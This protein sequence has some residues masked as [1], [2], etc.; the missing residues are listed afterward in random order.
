MS[1]IKHNFMG[2]KMNKDLDERLIPNGEYRDAM[3]IQVSTS[4]GS[5]VGTVQNILGNEL[6]CSS[7]ITPAG[8]VTVGSIADEKNDALYWLVAG[9]SFD[10]IS[11]VDLFQNNLQFASET[12]GGN[13]YYAKDMI[14]RRTTDGCEPVLVD[15][16]GGIFPNYDAAS[17]TYWANT[18]DNSIVLSNPDFLDHIHPGMSVFGIN[19]IDGS[20]TPQTRMVTNVGNLYSI[21]TPYTLGVD[22]LVSATVN[23]NTPLPVVRFVGVI[24]PNSQGV[25]SIALDVIFIEN[26]SSITGGI[27][28][29][30]TL[31]T[32]VQFSFPNNYFMQNA[33]VT[34]ILGGGLF[35]IDTNLGA[36]ETNFNPNPPDTTSLVGNNGIAYYPYEFGTMGAMGQITV[37][38]TSF[39]LT[40]QVIFPENSQWLNEISDLFFDENYVLR[41]VL[42]QLQ[43][44]AS[45][46]WPNGG[47]IDTSA[48]SLIA[49]YINGNGDL[50]YSNDY[51]IVDCNSGI[52]FANA[53][54][55][56]PPRDLFLSVL[57]GAF[58][59]EVVT[60]DGPLHLL[61]T[62]GSGFDYLVFTKERVLNF[63]P[64]KQ[65]TGI[66]II[67]DML[68]WVDGREDMTG[69]SKVVGTEPKKINIKRS[70]AGTDVSGD[71][72]TRLIN[73][74]ISTTGP[75]LKEEHI[76]VIRQSPKSALDFDFITDRE[77]DK[78][79]SGIMNIC[80]SSGANTSSFIDSSQDRRDFNNIKEGDH[81]KIKIE[82]DLDNS[83]SF[84][85][86]WKEGTV[87][88]LQ[89]FDEDDVAPPVPFTG[90]EYRIKGVIAKWK[91]NTGSLNKMTSTAGDPAQVSILVTSVSGFPPQTDTTLDYVVDTYFDTEKLFEFKFPRFS[92][93]YKYRDGEYSSFGPF[94]NVAFLPGNFNYH[95][96]KGYN[97]GMTNV[98]NA[99]TVK[100]FITQDMPSDVVAIDLLYKEDASPNI[101]IIDTIKPSDQAALGESFNNWDSNAYKITSDTIY[102]VVPS[103]QLLRSWDNV[104][105]K[106]LAQEVTG[107][108][109]VY[110][111]YLQNYDLTVDNKDFYPEFSWRLSA[112][113]NN[114]NIQSIK[115]L[116]DYQLGV[117]FTDKYGRETP[118]ITNSSGALKVAKN[119]ANK[120][121]MLS[122]GFNGSGPPVDMEYFKFFIKEISGEY[123]NIAMDRFFD[124]DDGNYWLAFPSSDRNKIDEDTFLILKKGHDSQVLVGD[125][126]RYKVLAIENEAPDYIKTSRY[127]IGQ[128]SQR[129]NSLFASLEDAPVETAIS[130]RILATQLEKSSASNMD[131]IKDAL[132]VEF[133]LAGSERLSN[134]YRITQLSKGS[135]IGGYYNVQIDG[136]FENDV[137]FISDGSEI[138]EGAIVRFY[139]YQVENKPIYDGKFFVKILSDGVFDRNITTE[140]AKE[141]EYK[142]VADKKVYFMS[143]DHIGRHNASATNGTFGANA[144]IHNYYETDGA[145]ALTN[146]SYGAP[147]S[148]LTS[149]NWYYYE[150]YFKNKYYDDTTILNSDATLQ[151]GFNGSYHTKSRGDVFED[152]M[153]ID[154]GH[155]SG[156]QNY[157]GPQIDFRADTLWNT[158]AK[159]STGVRHRS[160]GTGRMDLSF[161]SIEPEEV[162]NIQIEGLSGHFTGTWDFEGNNKAQGSSKNFWD[163][164]HDGREKYNHLA[165]IYNKIQSGQRFRWKEDP[166][167]TVYTIEQQVDNF[168]LVRFDNTARKG[169]NERWVDGGNPNGRKWTTRYYSNE[170]FISENNPGTPYVL[171]SNF[172]LTKR[173]T[174][175]PPMTGWDPTEQ[176]VLG[177]ISGGSR[178]DVYVTNWNDP[179]ANSSDLIGYRTAAMLDNTMIIDTDQYANIF[180]SLNG[181][182][183]A[184]NKLEGMILTHVNGT[185]LG[186]PVLVDSVIEVDQSSIVVL[187]FKGYEGTSGSFVIG[188]Q[189]DAD[190][191]VFRQPSMNGLSVNSAANITDFNSTTDGIGAVG[192]TLEF[193]DEKDEENEL[194]VNPAVWETEPKESTDLD[195]Y[196]EASSNNPIA[197]TPS[198]IKTVLQVGSRVSSID[199][200][201]SDGL[202]IATNSYFS[203]DTITLNEQLCV[204]PAGC[205]DS[206]GLVTT[207]ITQGDIFNV[208]RSNGS[209]I[210]VEVAEVL[211]TVVSGFSTI[212]KTFRLKKSLYN[213]SYALNWYN[214]YAFGNGVES[215]RIRDGFNLPYITNGV[216]VST[217]FEDEY[218]EEHRKYGLIYSGIYN[219]NSGT[220]NLNQFIQAEKITKDINPIYG[221]IQKL[222]SRST[223]DGDLIVLCEDRVLKILAAKDALFNADGNPQLIATNR[224]LGQA[225]P[226]AGEFGI[227]KNPESFASES[228]RVYF[229]D[230]VRGAVMRLSK[231]GLTAISNHGMKD[232]FRDNLKLP[233]KLMGS[234]DD[235]ND[236]YNIT[237]D[238]VADVVSYPNGR[239]V[240]FKEDVKGWV[241]FKSFTP[242]NAI[243]CANEYYTF[244]K[245]TLWQQH[246]ETE[247]RNTFYKTPLSENSFTP[248]SVNVILNESPSVIKTFHTLNYE[249]TQSKVKTFTNYTTS[250]G[251]VFNNEYYNLED[252]LGWKVQSITTDQEEGSLNEFI[253]KE[254]KWFNYIRGKAGSV[255][256]GINITSGFD[257]ADFSFQGLGTMSEEPV[258]S[259]VIG[260]TANGIN[261]NGAGVVNDFFGDGTAAFNYDSFALIEDPGNPCIQ[262]VFGC[263][264][265]T[266]NNYTGNGVDANGIATNNV[267][268]DNGTCTYLG[269]ADANATNELIVTSGT[270]IDDGTCVYLVYGCTDASTDINGVYS[271]LNFNINATV[272]CNGTGGNFPGFTA[273]TGSG[274]DGNNVDNC[275]CIPAVYGCMDPL[276]DNYN[277]TN[278]VQWTSS[279]LPS[280]PGPN[281]C[282]YIINGCM[283]ATSCS[284]NPLANVDDGSCNWCNE[285]GANNYDGVGA[286]GDPYPCN[287]G[288]LFCK[289]ITNLQEIF[290][291]PNSVDISWDETFAA[292]AQ[293]DHYDVRYSNDGGAN[294]VTI[295]NIQP[296]IVQGTVSYSLSGL[297]GSTSYIVEVQA[298]C[299]TGTSPLNPTW[300]TS[301]NWSGAIT[302]TTPQTPVYGCTDPNACNYDSTA[303]TN[304]GSCEMAS[305]SGCTDSIASNY[306]P[307][308]TNDDGSCLYVYGCTDP[309]ALNYDALATADDGSCAYPSTGCMDSSLANDGIN[310]A[311]TN[312]DPTATQD[313]GSCVYSMP[314]QWSVVPPGG[315]SQLLNTPGWKSGGLW[316]GGTYRKLWAI[317]DVSL[318]PKL[319]NSTDPDFAWENSFTTGNYAGDINV[320]TNNSWHYSNDGGVNWINGNN[321]NGT[322]PMQLVYLN[323]SDSGKVVFVGNETSYPPHVS[324]GAQ[325]QRGKFAFSNGNIPTHETPI[326]TYNVMLGCNDSNANNYNGPISF[327]DDSLCIY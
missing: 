326:A 96:T 208:E 27:L 226:F 198:T 22:Y 195:I 165:S 95:P 50:V 1:E 242:E 61:P 239:T 181:V 150:T 74:S 274:C 130:F 149:K 257:N 101:Y 276:A 250:A 171:S 129:D 238:T 167:Q 23:Q 5:H 112:P 205:T 107:N 269:C 230:K 298:V 271:M 258:T 93:R 145:Q 232:W 46:T 10:N 18:N 136:T 90:N 43:I 133:G 199:G 296:N 57:G 305:C 196:Y 132:Y 220:N 117:V 55:N 58:N 214:C 213:T 39:P 85:L 35:Q 270:V 248:S 125:K 249:G 40:N 103:N 286:D 177:P 33:V 62:Q 243:S 138:I 144:N 68:L 168:N 260:C 241:S 60:L 12:A 123:Y 13:P 110:G 317:W 323:Q 281:P 277:A 209:S 174:F 223:A 188:D 266:A 185:A 34:G 137:N 202:R 275:C 17:G 222:H 197:L 113:Q 42:P 51:Y 229:T 77:V 204:D 38:R 45:A 310:Y 97:L 190:H 215:N 265:V 118:V 14:M 194:P 263:I 3:N 155:Y 314:A 235:R 240:T 295:T 121:N 247:D 122:V 216:K 302:I 164:A 141:K 19:A 245:G 72:H 221:S 31:T 116:R 48:S 179:A 52:P 182:R 246:S 88:V 264:D 86:P 313:D 158:E 234:Y 315:P 203:G 300:N 154:K 79:Y 312:Y 291:N 161:G 9:T 120:N 224:V 73:D 211:D 92:Y 207:G 53:P 28:I 47:C 178:V 256:D 63:S 311:A 187:V 49:P 252:K 218:K 124:A 309:A 162:T 82:T 280:P 292:G 69:D 321:W 119:D 173:F 89:E 244:N 163:L 175:S 176:D 253:E 98:I 151:T 128:V 299:V 157:S 36:T 233:T 67:D 83:S 279:A 2:G 262:T 44:A 200:G 153:F 219:S 143:G 148:V 41:A 114:S 236:E 290:G 30:D 166:L 231:D 32:G 37:D 104:P 201:G 71:F 169:Y 318:S 254:G 134:R 131:E 21:S 94:T 278:N 272:G 324:N 307:T 108:R 284:F 255:S 325:Q 283:D 268:T 65:I 308:A 140:S 11:L 210:S 25:H 87:V 115:S 288:C 259:S 293:V 29:G 66:N 91:D 7:D 156:N 227:S 282:F 24:L 106:A 78:N 84:S 237:L 303:T 186:T 206:S 59:N 99:L 26:Q 327:Y 212:S 189:G 127:N 304:N 147:S 320:Y 146:F 172:Q 160:N 289:D 285:V 191:V 217:T 159:Q 75:P 316:G 70:I 15:Q 111:N 306:I 102:A 64:T 193:L 139:K 170:G 80:S 225:S 267:N 54:T 297:P 192:Y 251:N 294:Y 109:V 135:T 319:S 8:S 184:D 152:V 126:A 261:Q 273:V 228:Y 180:D 105:R 56:V 183:P 322:D 76:T 287:N 20:T 81:F 100:G 142:V 6:G 301:S 16:W 4:E